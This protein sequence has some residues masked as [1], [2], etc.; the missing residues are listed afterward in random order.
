MLLRAR[1]KATIYALATFF[2]A[3]LSFATT[4][5]LIVT[6]FGAVVGT[7]GDV[8]TVCT[9]TRD[10]C[11]HLDIRI[12]K[13]FLVQKRF[14]VASL[15]LLSADI[16]DADGRPLF[17]YDF[18]TW[19]RGVEEQFPRDGNITDLTRTI[20]KNYTEPLIGLERAIHKGVIALNSPD[21]TPRYIVLGYESGVAQAYSIQSEFDWHREVVRTPLVT[22]IYPVGRDRFDYGL[23]IIGRKSALEGLC[24]PFGSAYQQTL[25]RFRSLD[26]FCTGHHLSLGE[27]RSLILALLSVQ[28]ERDSTG[29]TAPFRVI[30]LKRTRDTS[31]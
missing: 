22:R 8:R 3:P 20:R 28:V 29:T 26:R 4:V 14:V 13:V 19:I 1:P 21:Q 24:N 15:G 5:I 6:P 12:P 30:T 23:R 31:R 2:C 11:P 10:I 16:L 17:Q 25:P 27:A 9:D 7:D 18:P